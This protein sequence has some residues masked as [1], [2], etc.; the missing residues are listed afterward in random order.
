MCRNPTAR[1]NCWRKFGNIW[2]DVTLGS[3]GLLQCMSSANRAGKSGAK[4]ALDRVP[5][6]TAAAPAVINPELELRLVGCIH[7][8]E[9]GHVSGIPAV[10]G[11]VTNLALGVTALLE[12][13]MSRRHLIFGPAIGTFED[14]H[15]FTTRLRVM[16]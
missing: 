10:H 7:E 6:L 5:W 1:A 14:D 15:R 8:R 13:Q 9:D 16:T 11:L 3:D 4:A 2:R 12:R